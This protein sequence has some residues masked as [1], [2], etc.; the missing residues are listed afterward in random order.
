MLHVLTDALFSFSS[1]EITFFFSSKWFK[2]FFILAENQLHVYNCSRVQIY[3]VSY[4]PS[5]RKPETKVRR[6]SSVTTA[7]SLEYKQLSK[8]VLWIWSKQQRWALAV[9][10]RGLSCFLRLQSGSA[11]Q[12]IHSAPFRQKCQT[13][14]QFQLKTLGKLEGHGGIQMSETTSVILALNIFYKL[15]YTHKMK[16]NMNF[17]MPEN[18]VCSTFIFYFSNFSKLS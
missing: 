3:T 2:F 15:H 12:W 1:E 5:C 13:A 11:F 9:C 8:Q 18:L 16:I 4:I 14:Q 7:T 6:E 10:R 17:R